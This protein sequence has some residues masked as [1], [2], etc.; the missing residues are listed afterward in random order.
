MFNSVH[1]FKYKLG[2]AAALTQTSDAERASLRR[3][4]DGLQRLVEIGVYHGVNTRVFREVMH[5]G[6]V[7]IAVDPFDRSWCGIRGYGWARRIAHAEV[8]K[9]SN[10]RVIWVECFGKDAP[11]RP[12]V[13]PF[14]PVDFIFIDGDHSYEGLRGDWQAWKNH[15]APG[16]VVALH[17]S[18]NRNMCGSERFTKE[19]ILADGDFRLVE[20]VDSLT[21]LKRCP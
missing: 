19:V 6:G 3:H 7:V 13:K 12:E 1:Y 9:P 15:V 14:L 20:V 5:P 10:G 17:D 21:M 8:G 11:E 16:G 18:N 2:L 4:A